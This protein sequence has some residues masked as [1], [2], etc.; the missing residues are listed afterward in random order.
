MTSLE[1]FFASPVVHR[2]GWMLLHSLWQLVL[3]AVLLAATLV[4]LRRRSANARYLAGC[5]ALV[6]MAALPTVTVLM[7]PGVPGGVAGAAQA[8]RAPAAAMPAR[9]GQWHLDGLRGSEAPSAA[10][11]GIPWH[12]RLANWLESHLRWIVAA[13][14]AGVSALSLRMAAGWAAA[15]RLRRRGCS[16]VGEPWQGRLAELGRRIGV[17]RPVQMLE[18]GLARVPTVIG[19]MRPVIL[20]PVAALTGLAPQQIEAIV[21]HEL[22]HIRR[23]D[24]LVNLAQVVMETLLFYHP[25]AW[26]VS[27]RIRVERENCCDDI[28]IEVCG[29][30]F[31]YIR[32]LVSLEESRAQDAPAA[33]L[34][35]AWQGTLLLE[36]ARRLLGVPAPAGDSSCRWTAGPVL[37]A[38]AFAI[39][40]G[41]VASVSGARDAGDAPGADE[42]ARPRWES[43]KLAQPDRGLPKDVR[44]LAVEVPKE[45]DADHQP[46][47]KTARPMLIQAWSVQVPAQL[48]SASIAQLLGRD[49]AAMASQPAA[50]NRVDKVDRMVLSDEQRHSLFKVV[51]KVAE[52]DRTGTTLGAPQIAL[53]DHQTA[54]VEVQPR[55]TMVV[56]RQDGTGKIT[57]GVPGSVL[58][59]HGD[60][61][62]DQ[63]I[64]LHVYGRS[65]EVYEPYGPGNAGRFGLNEAVAEVRAEVASGST[66]LV[67]MPRGSSLVRGYRERKTEAGKDAEI[68]LFLEPDPKAE[69]SG[70][71]FLLVLAKILPG[72]G[73]GTRGDGAKRDS[74]QPS[75]AHADAVPSP[76]DSLP[77]SP[78][79]D[80]ALSREFDA[81]M[82]QLEFGKAG[83]DDVLR[84][85]GEPRSYITG[86]NQTITKGEP[87]PDGYC[88]VYPDGFQIYMAQGRL[89]EF[90]FEGPSSYAWRGLHFGSSVEDMLGVM[91]APD[92]TITGEPLEFMDDGVLY[93]DIDGMK[94]RGYYQRRSS[95]GVRVF[96]WQDRVVAVYIGGVQPPPEPRVSVANQETFNADLPARVAQLGPNQPTREDIV[97]MFGPPVQYASGAKTYKEDELPDSYIM[98]Y[99]AGLQVYMSRDGARELHFVNNGPVKPNY[100]FRGKL[101][102]GASLDDVL[103]VLGQPNKVVERERIGFE[104]G[105]LYKDA[106]NRKGFGYY[107]RRDLG[108]RVFL[109][110]DRVSAICVPAT[111]PAGGGS[112]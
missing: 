2:L 28:A 103:A 41:L 7:V 62:A 19:H 95:L 109:Y 57:L 54:R 94:G 83:L 58:A 26:W 12:T 17:T 104:D 60:I 63:R 81:K 73:G 23:Y 42:L 33:G 49:E 56:P 101:R 40:L 61:V 78:P 35:V 3:V 27:R 80:E 6:L 86:P 88:M 100:A 90:R 85:F 74:Q 75:D 32:A 55:I 52:T 8:A 97:R 11:T 70:P 4:A 64:N 77:P 48:K 50:T 21:A 72:E 107:A 38:G 47:D 14:L 30:R 36:R 89:Y 91:G 96:L 108:V 110:G 59:V 46:E 112:R 102:V 67:Q 39:I 44:S 15:E 82:S 1:T 98:L 92:K 65:E 5:V 16:E 45:F 79:V 22:A 9:A 66:L 18:S 76:E 34:A 93:K 25:A 111:Q 69:P 68:D 31:A 71:M 106:E 13:W 105:V 43:Y 84:V 24:Y 37:L 29:D 87:M 99:P 10:D 20:L 53:L 51:M